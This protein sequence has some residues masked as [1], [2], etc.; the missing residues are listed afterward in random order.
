MWSA[1]DFRSKGTHRLK[2][3]GKRQSMQMEMKTKVA[4]LI[5]NIIDL[6]AK[7]VTRDKEDSICIMT[8][9]SIQQEDIMLL[10]EYVPNI[11]TL[12]I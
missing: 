12:K 6:K 10:N 7:T 4:I 8:K 11:V 9:G 5:T 2:V 1:R 3:R